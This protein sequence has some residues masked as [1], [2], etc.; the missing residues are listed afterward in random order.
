MAKTIITIEVRDKKNERDV[1]F[2]VTVTE[3]D[4]FNLYAK[5]T[6]A[7][8]GDDPSLDST[9]SREDALAIANEIIRQ[10][11]VIPP[12]SPENLGKSEVA[13]KAG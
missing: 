11:N 4:A 6:D 8:P 13:E 12:V 2:K 5:A 3:Q 9:L 1:Q 7:G 10:I